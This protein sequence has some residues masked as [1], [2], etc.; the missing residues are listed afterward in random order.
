MGLSI[1]DVPPIALSKWLGM[2]TATH[3]LVLV[4][5]RVVNHGLQMT[6]DSWVGTSVIRV[7]GAGAVGCR[8]TSLR[9]SIS[10]NSVG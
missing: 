9:P 4:L 3:G 10:A 7:V 6:N 5:S 1:H 8:C 2:V